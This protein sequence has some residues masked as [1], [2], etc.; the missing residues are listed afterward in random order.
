MFLLVVAQCQALDR[1]TS[2][3][4]VGTRRREPTKPTPSVTNQPMVVVTQ[5]RSRVSDKAAAAL[6]LRR[7]GW[8]QGADQWQLVVASY[9]SH[10][11]GR[12]CTTTRL[13]VAC[14]HGDLQLTPAA[15]LLL[16]FGPNSRRKSTRCALP[17][18]RGSSRGSQR[19][20]R[21]TQQQAQHSASLSGLLSLSPREA[22]LA[23]SVL[24]VVAGCNMRA[25]V[26][27]ALQ[28]QDQCHHH[29]QWHACYL[30]T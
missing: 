4:Q 28:L 10:S 13:V 16:L 26:C 30:A 8:R 11:A 23:H 19:S 7:C 6:G 15:T 2:V 17:P 20:S 25:A 1:N 22:C 21:G 29:W 18:V 14:R 5:Q 27:K 24:V 12:A 3:R 9:V